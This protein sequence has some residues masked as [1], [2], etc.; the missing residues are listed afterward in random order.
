MKGKQISKQPDLVPTKSEMDVLQVLWKHGPSTV[1]FVHDTLNSQKEAVQY[2]STLKLMQVMTEKGI[3]SRDETSMKHVY[4]PLLE[5]EKTKGF[6]LG[7]FV[8]SMYEG[9]VS[10]LVLALL[11]NEKTSDE[12]LQL[13]K[14]LAKQLPKQK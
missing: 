8:D 10:N 2:T 7:K 14:E 1:R 6:M 12:E 11:D 4:H 3:L 13:L 5:E 9:S